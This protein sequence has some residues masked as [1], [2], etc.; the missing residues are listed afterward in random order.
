MNMF[1][2]TNVQDGVWASLPIG[3]QPSVLIRRAVARSKR[4]K[5]SFPASRLLTSEYSR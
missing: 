3:H 1:L 5:S 2:G 4:H